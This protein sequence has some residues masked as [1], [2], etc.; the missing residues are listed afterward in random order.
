[1]VVVVSLGRLWYLCVDCLGSYGECA[2]KG[3]VWDAENI[4]VDLYGVAV[5]LLGETG[6]DFI[7]PEVGMIYAEAREWGVDHFGC[8]FGCELVCQL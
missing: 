1:M 2:S 4:F 3:G 7:G 5:V 8:A 6:A